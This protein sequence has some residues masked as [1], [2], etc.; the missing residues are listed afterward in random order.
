MFVTIILYISVK[1][2]MMDRQKPAASG[3]ARQAPALCGDLE[4]AG[5]LEMLIVGSELGEASIRLCRVLHVNICSF[6]RLLR[7]LHTFIEIQK[8][9]QW[10][11]TSLLISNI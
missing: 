3:T 10:R 1:S 2:K 4:K 5:Q 11:L 9:Q 6:I 8:T 7:I